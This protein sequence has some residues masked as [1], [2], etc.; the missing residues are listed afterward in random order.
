[1]TSTGDPL[2]R[3][4]ELVLRH[5]W[6]TTAYQLLNPGLSYWF[7]EEGDACAGYFVSRLPVE[8]ACV[9][10]VDE[11]DSTHIAALLLGQLQ[12]SEVAAGGA[13][14]VVFRQ[15]RLDVFLHELIEM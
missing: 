8:P 2:P 6:N 11:R 12:R 3:V 4:R 13:T 15:P 5:G 7:S 1:M 10:V 14:R 9:E